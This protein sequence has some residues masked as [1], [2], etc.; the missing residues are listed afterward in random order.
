MLPEIEQ[1]VGDLVLDLLRARAEHPEL[2]L[3][4]PQDA[5][6][7]VSSNAV[8]VTQHYTSALLAYGFA[9]EQQELRE[10]ADWFATPFPSDLHRRIDAVEMNRLEGLLSLRPTSDFVLPR[11]EQLARQRVTDDYFEIGGTPAF[12]TLWSI[13]VMAQARETGV[14]NGIMPEESL[15]EWAAKMVEINHRD[16]DLALALRLRYDLKSKLTAAQQKK[17]VEK[18]IKIAEQ[19]GGF[20]GL[21]QDMRALGENM[22]R[23]QL[24]P[25]QIADHRETFREMILSTCYVI[26]NMMP[27][28]DVYPQIE[29]LLRRAMELWWG[30][31]SGPGVVNTLRGLFPNPYDYLLIVCR[32]LV[33]ARVYINQPLINWVAVYIHRKLA[34]QQVRPAEP[35]DTESIRKAL[36]NWIRVDLE[37]LPEPLRLGMSDSN[38]VRIHPFIANPMQPEDDSFKLNIPNADSLI[39][40]YGPIEEIDLERDNYARLPPAIRDCFVNIPQPSF[41]DNDRRRAFVIMADLNRYRTLSDALNKVPQIHEALTHELGT[42]LVRVHM[43]EGHGRRTVQEGLL[44]QLYLLPMQQH[45]RRIFSYVLENRLLDTDDNIKHANQLQRDLLDRIG[46]LVRYQLELED[47]PIACMHGDLH[48]RNIMVRRLKQRREG[49]G[50]VDF[51]LIDLE[52]FRRVGDAALDAGELLV[53]L[54]ILRA[55]RNND[56]ARDPHAALI[57]AVEQTYADFAAEREDSTF[58]LRVRL[59]QARSLIRIAKGRTKQ[60]ELALKES[61]KGPAIRVAFD[62]LDDATQAIAH[63]DAVVSALG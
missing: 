18:L 2:V 46:H 1:T 21:A 40:K 24:F 62:V 51:K 20:W 38:V 37:K 5:R 14:L 16:K 61:R 31:F 44:L 41:V 47:F 59:G 12:D 36:K 54:E 28:V 8:R 33:T 9:P 22:H 57:K 11:L 27:L 29:P 43:G 48:S 58:A 4:S 52:K 32:T 17:Y 56:P 53:D 42:F 30:V 3:S 49:E 45:V 10:A 7:E 39:V 6:G 63:L 23:G 34:A 60:G 19:S 15:R 35:E 50:E 26:E 13:K 55:T 25:E